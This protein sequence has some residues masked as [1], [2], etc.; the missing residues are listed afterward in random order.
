MS[1]G[2]GSGRSA[3]IATALVLVLGAALPAVAD[4]AAASACRVRDS[5]TGAV[6][7]S[8]NGAVAAAAPDAQLV[9]RGRCVGP[10]V[11]VVVPLVIR[12]VR[13]VGPGRDSGPARIVAADRRPAMRID[14]SVDAL[15][16]AASVD[17]HGGIVIGGEA[18]P[19]PQEPGAPWPPRVGVHMVRACSIRRVRTNLADVVA[20]SGMGSVVSFHGRCAGPVLIARDLSL[21]GSRMGASSATSD[22]RG[23]LVVRRTDSGRSAIRLGGVDPAIVVDAAVT[24]LELSAFRIDDGFE[25]R[26]DATA[27]RP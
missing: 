18:G 23:R 4:A 16:I 12:G 5:G 17:V 3:S 10:T 26:S 19:V 1:R 13:A 24:A 9:V 14:P 6:F 25:I 15:T 7:T 20:S 27:G 11:E 22:R 8:L 21:R 2:T